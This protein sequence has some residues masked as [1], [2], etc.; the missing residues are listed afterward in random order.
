VAD[1][2]HKQSTNLTVLGIATWGKVALREQMI[3]KKEPNTKMFSAVT[4]DETSPED[5]GAQVFQI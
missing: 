1:E 2:F 4:R 3:A 5:S